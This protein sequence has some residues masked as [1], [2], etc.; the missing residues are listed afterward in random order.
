MKMKKVMTLCLATVVGMGVLSG[1]GSTK[2]EFKQYAKCAEVSDYDGVEYVPASREVTQDKIDEKIDSF[3]TDNNIETKDYDSAIKDGDDVNINYVETINGQE[4]N[5]NDD[6]AG[7][8]VVIVFD[9]KI[10]YIKITTTPEYT[11]DLVKS[12]TDGK[13]TTTEDYTKYLTDELQK[14]TDKTADS[15]DR[16]NVLKAIKEKTTFN[17]YPEGEIDSYVKSVMDNIESSASQYG[18]GVPT[19]LQYFYGYTDESAFVSYLQS[20]V[21]S[22]MQEKIVVSSIALE[23]NLVANDKETEAYKQKLMDDNEVDE[24]TINSKYSASDLKFYATEEKVLD[25]LMGTAVQVDSTEASSEDASED[26]ST[27][28][29]STESTTEAASEAE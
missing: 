8:S 5:K 15:T 9:I 16:A 22:V 6:E 29:E 10:N 26:G 3:C 7:T 2:S 21:E 28:A 14:D 25:Y 27:E 23:K 12:A 4:K 19:F 17:Q 11:D 13:Y 18:I 20:T 24:D 1:C